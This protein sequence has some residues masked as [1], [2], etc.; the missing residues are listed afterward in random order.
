MNKAINFSILYASLLITESIL[1]LVMFLVVDFIQYGIDI[2][3]IKKQL[4]GV[5]WWNYLRT[6]FYAAPSVILYL[7]FFRYLLKI[8]L[9]GSL[10]FSIFNLA[11]F[12]SLSILSRLIWGKNIPIDPEEMVFLITC[13]VIFVSPII[14]EQTRYF[15][16]LMEDL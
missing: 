16:R 2:F 3:Y 8:K 6:L 15:K 4:H 14:L 10:L 9:Y 5:G 12:V 13:L 1:M 7:M 11:T